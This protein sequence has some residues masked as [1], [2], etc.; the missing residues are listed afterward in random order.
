MDPD[1]TKYQDFFYD[2]FEWGQIGNG[3]KWRQMESDQVGRFCYYPIVICI[4]IIAF[5]SE[6][7]TCL[8]CYI[9]TYKHTLFYLAQTI[10]LYM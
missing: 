7:W 4:L 10:I 3:I 1:Y 6:V 5:D 8:L 9:H 2:N